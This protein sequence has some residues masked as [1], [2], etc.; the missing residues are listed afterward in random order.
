[1]GREERSKGGK[2]KGK[3]ETEREARKERQQTPDKE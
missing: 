3:T 1:M 2:E